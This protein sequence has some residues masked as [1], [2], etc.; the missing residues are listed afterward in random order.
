M[1][2]DNETDQGDTGGDGEMKV[3]ITMRNSYIVEEV[4]SIEEA[5]SI[6]TQEIQVASESL[7][8]IEHGLVLTTEEVHE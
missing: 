2:G 1:G 8:I 3:R 6:L 7:V 5:L 4:E